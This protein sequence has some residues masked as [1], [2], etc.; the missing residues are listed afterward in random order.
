[1]PRAPQLPPPP[2]TQTHQPP[3]ACK[4]R[5]GTNGKPPGLAP[6]DTRILMEHLRRR[7]FGYDDMYVGVAV[8]KAP[9][10]PN[11]HITPAVKKAFNV[12]WPHR[13]DL[14]WSDEGE[15]TI[16]EIKPSASYLAL[17]QL[18]FYAHH[19]PEHYACLS[20]AHLAVMTDKAE[21]CC[22]PLFVRHNITIMEAPGLSLDVGDAQT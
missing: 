2:D 15:W 16:C 12:L 9:P 19:A 17:G 21:P 7:S 6:N 1:M 3:D 4:Y 14:I 10:P 13:V 5:A 20:S 22:V 11:L 18:L 8:T